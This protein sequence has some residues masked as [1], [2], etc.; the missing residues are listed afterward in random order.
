MTS[1][2]FDELKPGAAYAGAR[3]VVIINQEFDLSDIG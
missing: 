2:T 3:G 1:V